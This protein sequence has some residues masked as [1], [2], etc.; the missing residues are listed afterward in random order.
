[1]QKKIKI[2][3]VIMIILL[4]LTII[5]LIGR[6]IIFLRLEKSYQKSRDQI[7]E[8]VRSLF[9]SQ[10]LRGLSHNINIHGVNY[11]LTS[12]RNEKKK[13]DESQ[14][15]YLRTVDELK[16]L[17]SFSSANDE[18]NGLISLQNKKL[19]VLND[20]QRLSTDEKLKVLISPAMD[21]TN[22]S[23]R[24][25]L[26]QLISNEKERYRLEKHAIL[27]YR[28]EI[29]NENIFISFLILFIAA[30]FSFIAYKMARRLRIA[31][32]N[33]LDAIKFREEILA[34]VSHDL[35]NPLA[36]IS[37]NAE[38]IGRRLEEGR[39][40]KIRKGLDRISNSV[41]VMNGLIQD[42][43]DQAKLESGKLELDVHD[44]NF[45]EVLI[46]S[47]EILAPISQSKS[48][49]IVNHV[50]PDSPVVK[51]DKKRLMQILTN[52]LSN[53][54]KF[55]KE[56]GEVE[57]VAATKGSELKVSIHDSG[58]GIAEKDIPFLFDRYWQAKK[59]AKQGTGLGLAIVKGLVK[60]HGGKIWVESKLGEGTTFT[61]TLPLTQ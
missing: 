50:P 11:F 33:A 13:L 23:L 58:S 25:R 4:G 6:G 28:D 24:F 55:S 31:H 43:L 22:K 14:N 37:L 44:E 5:S 46:N 8:N 17:P 42:L 26:D 40:E 61:F 19:Q 20:N 10:R 7:D 48:I 1:M 34:V 18:L 38:V 21:F 36:S 15:E 51:A 54:L 35:K 49:K 56:G 45:N 27:A 60:A 52:L 57:V 2:E 30:T 39:D 41:N 53:A 16:K 47:E 3:Y 12:N 32:Q 59:T 29:R 9:L